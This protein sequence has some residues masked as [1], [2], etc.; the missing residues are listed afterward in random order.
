PALVGA[1]TGDGTAPYPAAGFSMLGVSNP[2]V[3]VWAVKPA[4]EA[5]GG[6]ILRVWNQAGTDQALTV[7]PGAGIALS[8]ARRVTHIETDIGAATVTGGALAAVVGHDRMETYRL[9]LSAP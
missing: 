8:A 7:T 4:E 5:R 3:L 2:N 1:V 6:V 9:G